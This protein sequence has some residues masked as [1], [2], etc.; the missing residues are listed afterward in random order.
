[1][2]YETIDICVCTFRRP[3]LDQTLGSIAAQVLPAGVVARIIVADN[4]LSDGRRSDIHAVA[5][6]L[7]L[8]LCYVHAPAR[9]ISIARNACLAAASSDWIAFI[10]DD[11]EAAPDWIAQLVR[12]RSGAN[13]IFGVSQARYPDPLTPNWVVKG[14]FHSNRIAGNDEPWNGYTANVL[15]DRRFVVSVGLQF[16]VE[17]G[18]VGGE[19]TRFFQEAYRLGAKFD[20]APCAL[21]WED[22]PLHRAS[23]RWLA[24]R[25]FRSGQ[26]HYLLVERD[27]ARRHRLALT[28][29]AK[30]LACLGAA[31]LKL[32][33]P[34]AARREALRGM[35]HVGV[36]ASYLGFSPYREYGGSPSS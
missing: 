20:Y 13:V 30:A 33:L 15:I 10:D 21:V 17:L 36:I 5:A 27:G 16:A 35:L 31:A 28:A 9:N 18:Q 14:D 26:V 29:T 23:F 4:D 6:R 32:P 25:R 34:H 3:S 8:D 11:E 1:M 19:D 12:Q 7:A 2:T 22:T 24:L